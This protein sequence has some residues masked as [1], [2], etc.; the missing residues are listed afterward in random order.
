MSTHEI[1]FGTLSLPFQ[2]TL[3]ALLAALLALLT[4]GM[5]AVATFFIGSQLFVKQHPAVVVPI[6]SEPQPGAWKIEGALTE[7]CT[8]DVPCTCNFGEGPSPHDYCHAFYAYDIRKGR[9]NDVSLDGLR[10]GATDMEH[11]RTLFIDER[12]TEKQREALRV[13]IARVILR[14]SAGEAETRAREIAKDMRYL[15]VKQEYDNRRNRLEV[16][17]IGEFAAD[18]IMGL[19]KT[20]P[21]VVRNNTTWRIK[22]AIKA[23]TSIYRV[24]V[25]KDK[26]DVKNTNSNQGGFEYSD[27]SDFGSPAEWSCGACANEK[28]HDGKKEAMC[29]R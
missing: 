14:A 26:I 13:I 22:D 7:A 18:Y 28:A 20:Q 5:F 24:K 16:A 1:R 21:V 6:A 15:S 29:G 19:D 11:G 17:G 2:E 8:C 23:K 27:K 9:Y 12:A 3:R 4:A 25:G 10:F